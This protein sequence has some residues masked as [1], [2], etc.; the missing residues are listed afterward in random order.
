MNQTRPLKE[1]TY[2]SIQVSEEFGPVEVTVDDRMIKSFAFTQDDYNPWHFRRSP[3]GARIGHAAILAQDLLLLFTTVYDHNT[4]IG[5]HA[6]QELLFSN[7]VFLGETATLRCRYVDKYERRGNGYWVMAGEAHGEDG[8]LLISHRAVEL[9]RIT[10]STKVGGGT[11]PGSGERVTGEYRH[12]LAPAARARRGLAPGTPLVSL[13]KRTTIEQTWVFS[14]A[15]KYVRT[16]HTDPERAAVAGFPLTV[17]QGQQQACYVAELLTMFFGRLWFT[18][19]RIKLKFINPL[20]AGET[21]IVGGVVQSYSVDDGGS[22]RLNLDVW[23]RNSDERLLTV[24]WAS[25]ALEQIPS[26]VLE[27]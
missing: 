5:L 18:S 24:G 19:G 10:S 12:D 1:A 21:A 13:T 20:L 11:A 22:P 26:K 8:R 7:P 6:E 4:V 2:E 15:R 14:A 25:A 3:F 16:I 27:A 9:V 23:V 17:V